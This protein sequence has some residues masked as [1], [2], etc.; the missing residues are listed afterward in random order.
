MAPDGRKPRGKA[1]AD[2]ALLIALACGATI[3]KAAAETGI[4][5]RTVQRRLAD[6]AFQA[7][8]RQVRGEFL[9]RAGGALVAASMR[10]VQTLLSLQ[11]AAQ[12]PAVRLGAARAVL[13]LG[14]RVR[15]VV[16]LEGRLAALEAALAERQQGKN[17]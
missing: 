13:E 5:V 8:L 14:M 7:R 11:E 4:A 12:P 17:G 9:E 2:E 1:T 6:P 15:E 10:S 16:D 3:P